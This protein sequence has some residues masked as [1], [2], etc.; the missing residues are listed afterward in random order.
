MRKV[1]VAITVLLCLIQTNAAFAQTGNASVGGFVQDPS[2]AFI[3]G[4]TVTAL[5]TQTGVATT[6]VTNESGAYNVP[7]LLPGTYKLSAELP[8]FRTQV[9][10]DV[11]LGANT[12]ARY[13]FTLEVGAVTEAVEVTAERTA[14]LAETSPTIGQVLPE[15]QVRDLPL[16][17]TNVLDLMKT[18]PGVRGAG[19]GIS[20]TFAGISTNY[21]NTV[22][23][24][25]SVQEGRYENGVGSTTLINPDMVGEFRVILTPVDAELG[26]GNGQVQIITRSGTNEF[27]GSAVWNVRNSA[28]DANTWSNNKQIVRGVWTPGRPAWIN[29][30]EYTASLGGPIVKNKT[31]F[32]ALWGQQ[33]ERQRNTMRPAVL[34][35][36][37]RNGIFRYW[38]GWAN[39]NINTATSRAGANPTIASVDSFGNPVRPATN[40]DGT[41]YTG[42]LRYFSVFGPLLNTPAR[43]DCSDATVQG[44]AWDPLRPRMDPA[45]VSQKYLALMPHANI[46]DGGDGLNTGIHQWV[47]SAHGNANLGTAS[48]TSFDADNRQINTKID[49]TFS[50][51]HKLAANYSF[52]WVDNE[53]IRNPTVQWPGGYSSPTIRRPRVLTVNFTSTLTPS[54]LNEARFGYRA[55]WHYVWAPWEVPD[56]KQREVPLSLLQQGGQGFPIAY[57]PAMIGSTMPMNFQVNG[58]YFSCETDCA[59][60]GN[61][62][63][64]FDYSD[65]I[66]W[67][68]GKH[69]FRGGADFRVAY[70]RGYETPTAPIPKATGGAGLNPTQ[71]FRN[72]SSIPGFVSNNETMAN[73]LLYF[74]AGS[75]NNAQ[76]YY[77][78]ETPDQLTKWSSYLDH[79]RKLTDAHQKDFSVFFKDDWKVHPSF[80]LNLGVRYEYY[81][82]PYEGAGLTPSPVGGGI[83]LFGV[84][85]RS[86]DRWMRTDNPVDLNLLTQMELVGPKTPNPS[87]SLYKDDWNNFGPAAG[88]AWQLPWFG[89]QKTNIRGGYQITYIKGA[90]LS[91]LVNSIFI[92]QGFLNL[93]QTQGPTDGT[94]FDLRNLAGLVPIPPNGLPMQPI[95][96]LKLNQNA[97]AFDY[98]YA[99][100][101]VQNYTLSVTRDISRNFNLDVRYIGTRGLKLNGNYD[102]NS[103]NVFYNPTLFD[104]F[105]RTR[106]GED[107]PLLDQMFLGLNLNPGVRGCDSSN[108]TALCA[109]IDGRTQR[110]SAH[111]RT[112][113]TFRGDLANGNYAMVANALNVYNGTGSGAA[114][115]VVGVP[116]E[117]G[118][119]LRRANKGFN[120]PG[121]TT[122]TGGLVVPAGLFPE[123]WITANPQLNQ[124][125]YY[126]NSGN[127]TYHSMQVQG[128][129]RP[130]QGLSF[131]GTY[132]WSR[133]LEVPSTGYTNPTERNQDYRLNAN[134]VTHDF[135]SF[136]VFE[137]P[138][139]PNRLFFHNTS[140]WAARLAEGWQTSFIVNLSTGSPTSVTA[141]N[142]LYANGV[143]D[144][145]GPFSVNKGNVEWNGDFGNYFGSSF[146]KVADPQC[147]LV[148]AELRAYCTLQAVTDAKT[149]QLVL[150]NPQ[151]G[152]RGTLGST[153]MYLP[154]QWSF[155]AAIS[156]SIRIRESKVL[157]I[158]VDS[159]NIFNHPLPNNPNFNINETSPFGFIQDKGDQRRQFKAQLRMNF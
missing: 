61:H 81:G 129:L 117:R 24:G 40:A 89:K 148:A 39:G 150:Q 2:R 55:N 105:E 83:A 128:T 139:G 32:F 119:V 112:S 58:N 66:S 118:T 140:G 47:R 103:P 96:L 95:P 53:Y 131:Q 144:V 82:V 124:A 133:A 141:A 90:S 91:T 123:N 80:T 31:F 154:G 113:S 12:A 136:G 50:A 115:A 87:K 94:Y 13:N 36:C 57:V 22:R 85:G 16:V 134:H 108:P 6:V 120:V 5:N 75:L 143:A 121:G 33:F 52:Q 78:I 72:N 114:G 19:L 76:Q 138:F 79:T 48:G 104:A 102:L 28:L 111:L 27:R 3:P 158:R 92:N 127:S 132:V 21:V 30:N 151:P 25:I 29:R 74:L 42:Q 67:T 142:M 7:S 11:Q 20:T 63:P 64:L 69:A 59:Q 46:F 38:D 62:T 49:H 86:F 106:R 8:G 70:S 68:K 14:L 116:G 100:P 125:N 101:Y 17:S 98:N 99:S 152:K 65:T 109:P 93:A 37:A 122:L 146:I 54:L 15:R 44:A 159:T 45:G 147:G 145:L 10:N 135:R 88:F 149:G 130:T 60:Q 35:D 97:N 34:T 1:P 77:Y 71:V 84:S 137:L 4:V 56:A 157:Q 126:T 110:G 9:Y 18:M 51:R 41:P 107:V 153:T 156:K 43:S 73:Q 23:D 26:R 155:D